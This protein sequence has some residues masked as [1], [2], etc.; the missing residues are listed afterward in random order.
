[1]PDFQHYL[2]ELQSK[3][4]KILIAFAVGVAF[5]IIRNQ[6]IITTLISIFNLKNINIVL[7]SPYQFINLAV[8]ISILFGIIFAGPFLIYELLSF[9][10]PALQ[11]HEYKLII[12]LLPLSVI[13]FFSGF[14]FGA[15][16]LQFV[17]DIYVRTSQSF[18]I[19]NLWDVE[20]FLTQ[21]VV[22]GTSM[23]IVFQLPI[24]LTILLRLGIIQRSM[25][26]SK[27]RYVY[28][29][30]LIFD[31]FLP[32]TDILSLSLIFIPLAMLFEGT[33]LFN[34]E[35]HLLPIANRQNSIKINQG[36]KTL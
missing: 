21:I 10:R 23:G 30:L 34:Q 19:G 13:L 2:P 5:G 9:V 6:W 4:I 31:V 1:M 29:A 32:P 27:R 18:N 11:E 22:M 17:I 3:L 20:A 16:I 14:V 12:H 26:T 25:L 24:V 28:A 15:R 36:G 33:L 8:S 35:R 7:V